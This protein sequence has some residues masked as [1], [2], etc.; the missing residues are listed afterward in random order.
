MLILLPP[1]EGK[2][3]PRRGRPVDLHALSSPELTETRA[4]I[5]STLG[6]LCAERPD[7]AAKAL[8]LGPTQADEI[9][10]NATL[11][12]APAAP[13]RM[14]YTGVLFD[15]LG[16][17]TLTSAAAARARRWLLI[18]SGLWGVLRTTDRIPAYRLGGGV[19]LP[20][21][22]SL[23]S[24]WKAPLAQT[25]PHAAGRGLVVDL[26]SG[27]YDAFWRPSGNLAERTVKVRVL[28]EHDGKRTVVS[29]HNKATKGLLTRALLDDG[30]TPRRPAELAE[31]VGSLGWKTELAEPARSGR[32]WTLDVI[33]SEVP[34]SA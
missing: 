1:S 8:G 29:H 6:H 32:T 20:G 21:V 34:T 3:A 33:V 13:A 17:P 28:H 24:R 18:V 2:A 10:R 19:N 25:I 23:A 4:E 15:A 31:L 26:R 9:Q 16:L 22:G 11:P 5:M 30:G 12:D 14:V 27:T 7:A